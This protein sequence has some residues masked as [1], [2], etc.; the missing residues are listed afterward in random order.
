VSLVKEWGL[1]KSVFN[2]SLEQGGRF[3]VGEFSRNPDSVTVK[4]LSRVIYFK[5]SV[6]NSVI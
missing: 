5:G 6:T 1:V 2:K 4:T 3:C